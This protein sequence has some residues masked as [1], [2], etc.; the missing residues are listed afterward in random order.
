MADVFEKAFTD[1]GRLTIGDLTGVTG[2]EQLSGARAAKAEG[3]S[4][5]N[6]AEFNAKIAEREATA[7]RD[8]ATFEQQQQSKRAQRVKSQLTAKVA[9]AGG[10]GSPVAADL[11]SEQAAELELE[12]LLIGFEGEIGAGRALSQAEIDRLAGRLSKQRGRQEA[13]RRNIQF[14]TSLA[15]LTGFG[16]SNTAGSG[17]VGAGTTFQIGTPSAT[18]RQIFA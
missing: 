14:A 6:I 2:F 10:A 16:G 7:I 11:A 5:Q 4:R 9:A 15:F 3:Q 17:Q 8:K 12:N 18:P 1:P 13:N